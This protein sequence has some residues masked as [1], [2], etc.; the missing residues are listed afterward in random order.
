MPFEVQP[1]LC[2]I[3]ATF[4]CTTSEA[5][6]GKQLSLLF[7]NFKSKVIATDALNYGDVH[8]WEHGNTEKKHLLY[9]SICKLT[10]RDTQ[11]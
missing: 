2:Y 11:D 8:T 7:N 4:L 3:D 6:H 9:E 5:G 1:Q 10:F